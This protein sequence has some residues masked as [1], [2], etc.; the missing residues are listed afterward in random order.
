MKNSYSPMVKS[1]I[2][3]K[4]AKDLNRH[5]FQKGNMQMASEPKKRC[6]LS[7]AIREMRIK[8]PVRSYITPTRVEEKA[9]Q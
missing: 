5:F 1:Q 2:I 6:L 7:L 3:K 4:W 8:T 9:R